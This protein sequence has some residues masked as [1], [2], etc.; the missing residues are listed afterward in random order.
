MPKDKLFEQI[1]TGVRYFFEDPPLPAEKLEAYGDLISAI[2]DDIKP[3]GAIEW[4]WLK[5]IVLPTW[6]IQT[7]W[8]VKQ[9]IIERQRDKRAE[10]YRQKRREQNLALSASD[11]RA[12][13]DIIEAH[14]ILESTIAGNP[15]YQ[16]RTSDWQR[17][18]RDSK[19]KHELNSK[20]ASRAD[21]GQA[22]SQ[23]KDSAYYLE[24][25]NRVSKTDVGQADS[26]ADVAQ[27]FVDSID[28]LEKLDRMIASLERGRNH[29]LREIELRREIL[30]RRRRE[31]PARLVGDRSSP[32]LVPG[33]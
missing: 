30:V 29:T 26:Q 5:D 23:V 4:L 18:S 1:P 15:E 6:W 32:A 13:G 12:I 25:L 27:A 16:K 21:V 7:L 24:L 17:P 31:A 10:A 11:H 9:R 14:K 19:T 3:I 20:W 22:D 33:E 2:A 28:L 8:T